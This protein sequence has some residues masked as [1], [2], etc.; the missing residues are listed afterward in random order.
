MSSKGRYKESH[1]INFNVEM[2]KEVKIIY[3]DLLMNEN[4]NH[5]SLSSTIDYLLDLGIK[6]HNGKP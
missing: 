5:V 2:L 6:A 3:A 1:N 4:E